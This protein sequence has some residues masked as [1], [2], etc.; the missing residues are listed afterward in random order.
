MTNI[1]QPWCGG[2]EGSDG[3]PPML[4]ANFYVKMA[5]YIALLLVFFCFCCGAALCSSGQSSDND[6][7]ADDNLEE[8]HRTPGPVV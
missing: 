2:S 8:E 4:C 6:S 3:N 1:T 5:F 7:G